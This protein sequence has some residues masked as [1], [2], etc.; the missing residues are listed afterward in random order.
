MQ[1]GF[2]YSFQIKMDEKKLE[3]KMEEHLSNT[4][5]DIRVALQRFQ[6]YGVKIDRRFR[7]DFIKRTTDW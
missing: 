2:F 5:W 6:D 3:A 1:S 4:R 7:R